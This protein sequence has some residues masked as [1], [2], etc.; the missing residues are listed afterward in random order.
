MPAGRG[1]VADPPKKLASRAAY[2]R[3]PGW[4]ADR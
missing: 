3:E 4:D 1:P 2:A